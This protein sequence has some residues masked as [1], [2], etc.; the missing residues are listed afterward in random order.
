MSSGGQDGRSPCPCLLWTQRDTRLDPDVVF[1]R[2]GGPLSGQ[3]ALGVRLRGAGMR[4]QRAWRGGSHANPGPLPWSLRFRP[5][6]G[7]QA[8]PPHWA[9][10]ESRRRM[11]SLWASEPQARLGVYA[12]APS[13]H[14]HP[15]PGGDR[16]GV[17]C[18]W[19]VSWWPCVAL[20]SLPLQVCPLP[21]AWTWDG[22]WWCAG[23]GPGTRQHVCSRVPPL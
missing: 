17:P 18:W 9:D 22:P 16:R 13:L 12:P 6:S 5:P 15:F 4:R 7:L 11:C 19:P 20:L 8:H 23:G 10:V 1:H 21:H 2:G 14:L 3:A